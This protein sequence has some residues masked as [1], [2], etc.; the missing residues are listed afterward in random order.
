M[1]Y[2]LGNKNA[3]NGCKRTTPVQLI[4]VDVVTCF[5]GTQCT[6]TTTTTTTT[7]TWNYTRN[8]SVHEMRML[9]ANSNPPEPRHRHET[10]PPMYSACP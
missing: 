8:S 6:T 5:F 2:T 1:A 4:V 9:L 10:L 3:K 7:G